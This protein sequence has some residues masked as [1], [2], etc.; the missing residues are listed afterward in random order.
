MQDPTFSYAGDDDP[1]WWR[2]T[3]RLVERAT[4]QARLERMYHECRR[5]MAPG[6]SFWAAAMKKLAIDMQ[7]DAGKLAAAP[8]TGPLLFVSNH[9]FGVL[10]G[11]ALC[12]LVQTVRPDF[13]VL[14][15]AVLLKAPEIRDFVLPIDLSGDPASREANARARVEA[16]AFLEQG[17]ALV[18]F[19][20]GVVSTSP[21]RWGAQPAIDPPWQ[22]FVARMVHGARC[23]VMPVHFPGQN[24]RLFQIASHVSQTVRLALLFHEVRRRIGTPMP[25]RVGD[26]IPYA[27]LEPL[28]D[29]QALVGELRRRS[30]ALAV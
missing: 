28:R 22:P 3:I 2:T 16:R 18:L 4:G 25:I 8:R 24:S 23:P 26:A 1:F 30:E 20:S 6:E 15:N 5:Q 14:T 13:R 17:G 9:P 27:D 7:Y 19:P 12:S 10:D 11:I 21:D 29:R